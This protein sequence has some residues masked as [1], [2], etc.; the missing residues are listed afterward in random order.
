MT[1]DSNGVVQGAPPAGIP[2]F[3][4]PFAI[5]A[6]GTAETLGQDT[7]S[8]IVQSVA[9]LV[10]TRPGTRL[11]APTYGITDPTFGRIDQ[12]ELQLATAKWEPRAAVAV[13]VT[14]GN[15][16]TVVVSVGKKTVVPA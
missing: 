6:Y 15:Q 8:E 13:A 1:T 2:H 7:I 10:G 16:E 14:P 12:V 5:D 9:N 11:M 3:A 4:V